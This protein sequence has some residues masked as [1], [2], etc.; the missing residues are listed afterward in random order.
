MFV[1]SMKKTVE[2]PQSNSR[3]SARGYWRY[4]KAKTILTVGTGSSCGKTVL[5]LK[6]YEDFASRGLK[7]RI[8][9][10]G[11]DG[12]RR[13]GRGIALES[14]TGHSIAGIIEKEIEFVDQQGADYIIVEGQGALNNQGCSGVTLGLMHGV[15]PDAMILCHQPVQGLNG[16]ESLI[17]IHEDIVRV[18][19]PTKIVGVGMS[20][21]GLTDEQS[22]AEEK[23]LE[24]ETGLPVIDASRF[25][26]QKLSDALLGYFHD[27]N[28][29][30]HE[31]RAL[32]R[33]SENVP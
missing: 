32:H 16:I 17:R 18:F 7:A 9:A 12:I 29:S 28:D 2:I 31:N 24:V 8:I 19:R 10:T 1:D 3:I 26:V 5:A 14:V 25:G 23:R 30:G 22:V 27:T 33:N 13:I 4:R 6:L 20:A 15:M 11:L 21:A